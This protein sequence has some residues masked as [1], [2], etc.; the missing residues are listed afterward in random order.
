[1]DSD[2]IIHLFEKNVEN[3]Y[4]YLKKFKNKK[5]IHV[6]N[7]IDLKENISNINELFKNE[8]YHEISCKENKGI[9]ELMEKIYEIFKNEINNNKNYSIINRIRHLKIFENVVVNLKLFFGFLFKI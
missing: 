8:K 7:K 9:E 3:D 6:L 1:M 4:E 2:L 5:I